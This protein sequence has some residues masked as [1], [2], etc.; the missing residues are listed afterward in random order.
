MAVK[1]GTFLVI[2]V[3]LFALLLASF[4]WQLAFFLDSD[5]ESPPTDHDN[6][7]EE[8]IEAPNRGDK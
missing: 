6:P 3:T 7:A 1:K 4:L 5:Y 8:S 2:S